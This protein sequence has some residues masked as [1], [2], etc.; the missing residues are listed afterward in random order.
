MLYVSGKTDNNMYEVT[1]TQTNKVETFDKATMKEMLIYGVEIKGLSKNGIKI[2]DSNS[3][4][5]SNLAKGLLSGSIN[6]KV[7]NGVLSDL[8]IIIPESVKDKT[9]IR[10]SDYCKEIKGDAIK[11]VMYESKNGRIEHSKV[12]EI[13]FDNDLKITDG[14][15]D[16]SFELYP[17]LGE[18][19]DASK[20][21]LEPCGVY[22]DYLDL[23]RFNLS[24]VTD[25]DLLRHIYT[26]RL[27][28]ILI[29]QL[30][31]FWNVVITP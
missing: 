13:V 16:N 20:G 1:D 5:K 14:I 6:A 11:D 23:I 25:M 4:Y 28:K 7:N 10:L 12:V 2:M 26:Y 15:F 22:N 17:T 8:R 9:V 30:S 3:V 19:E 18:F 27:V 21:S 29:F 24:E 31:Y